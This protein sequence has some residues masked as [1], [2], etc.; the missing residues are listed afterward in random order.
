MQKKKTFSMNSMLNESPT[1]FTI[2]KLHI[3]SDNMQKHMNQQ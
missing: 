2:I 3:F 1:F